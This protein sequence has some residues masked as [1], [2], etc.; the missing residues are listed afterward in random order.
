VGDDN[1]LYVAS[2]AAGGDAG[3]LI[4]L[5]PFDAALTEFDKNSDKLLA[6]DELAAGPVKQRFP[7]IDRDKS[8][9]ITQAEYDYFRMLFDKSKNNVLAIRP[10][11]AGDVTA[12]HVVWEQSKLVPF[13]ASPV[14]DRGLVFTVKDGGI[15]SSLDAATG[16]AL[17]Q[18][19]IPAT[20]EYY[21]SP[22]AGD[23]KVY[24][25]NDEGK[26]TV[27]SADGKWEVLASADFAEPIYATPALVDG[28]IYLRTNGHLY[29][30]G[31]DAK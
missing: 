6:E 28:R 10:G 26:V 2:W 30:F 20:N 3:E 4:R 17:K 5:D 18:G 7:Q 19:R 24:F 27:V 11:G 31:G 1:T 9:T 8:G 23:G 21:A 14:F 12:T 29:C 25:A 13:C 22:V 16:K 15:V